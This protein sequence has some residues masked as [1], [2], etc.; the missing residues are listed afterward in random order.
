M[1]AV[2]RAIACGLVALVVVAAQ[3][4]ADSLADRIATLL[5]ATQKPNAPG[6]VVLVQRGDKVLHER[7][8]GMADLER[9][10]ALHPGSVLDIGSTSK[11]FTAASVLLLEQDRV[12]ALADPVAKH[13]KEVPACCAKVTLRHLLLHTSGIPDY[14]GLMMRGDAP[15]HIEDRTT[16]DDALHALAEVPELDF[17][18]GSKW[19]YSNSN[20]FLLAT[21]VERASGT[22]LT[23]FAKKRIFEPLG[24]TKTHIHTDCT[25]LV[26]DRAFSYSRARSGGWRWNFSNWEQSGDGAVMTTVGDLAKWARNFGS[27]VVGGPE[28]R[29]AMSKPGALDD[30]TALEYGAGLMFGDLEGTPCI[31]HG[32]A[33]AAYRAELLRVPSADLVVVCLCN[34]DDLEPQA[35]CRKIALAVL[36]G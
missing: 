28:L 18:A 15:H 22:P 4:P 17:A 30:G 8:H 24:M 5:R 3:E 16:A 21:V 12:L 2:V 36:R 1:L 19:A 33:W 26:P 13:V 25:Q 34:R 7:G 6:A 27:G 31:S 35:L 29:T 23:E 10:I 11:Q 20:Y 14:I 32:G 9:A